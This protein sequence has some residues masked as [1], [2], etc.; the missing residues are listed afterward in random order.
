MSADI[1]SETLADLGRGDEVAVAERLKAAADELRSLLDDL[2]GDDGQLTTERVAEILAA[3][4]AAGEAFLAVGFPVVEYA[5]SA[6]L[7]A[8]PRALRH[9]VGVTAAA[10]TDQTA[11]R[12]AA[13]PAVGR[14]VWALSS[15]TLHCDRLDALVAL[16]RAR[17]AVPF[18]NDV[19]PV[20]AL[21]TLR[22]PNAFGQNAGHAFRDYATWLAAR[23][24]VERYP[25]LRAELD[26]RLLEADLL[27]AMQTGR[28]RSRVYSLGRERD[29]VRRLAARVD[30]G[31]QRQAL[32]QLFPGE[33]ELEVRLEQ[34]YAATEGDRNRFES[35]PSQLFGEE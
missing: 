34:A 20:V 30:D 3:T 7:A 6:A 14:L 32:A 10:R 22:H 15:F 26:F 11:R 5:D 21:E 8:L 25:L 33:G 27:L 16:A 1:V 2:P 17:V 12:L 28:F 35:G 24:L 13:V 31:A 23:P 9:V 4:D 19:Q 18:S 29:T